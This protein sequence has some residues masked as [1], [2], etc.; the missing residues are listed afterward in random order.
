[1]IVW[2]SDQTQTNHGHPESDGRARLFLSWPGL[3][4]D[5][6][7]LVQTCA[8]YCKAQ[9]QRAQPIIQSALPKLLW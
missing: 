2:E 4:R 1:M 7:E 6:E 3:F 5:P 9:K 8:M